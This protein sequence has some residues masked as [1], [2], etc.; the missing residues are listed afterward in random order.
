MTVDDIADI[1][2]EARGNV[3]WGPEEGSLLSDAIYYRQ[4]EASDDTQDPDEREDLE[5]VE[6]YLKVGKRL[7][8][9][10]GQSIPG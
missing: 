9:L 6:E 10:R 7:A 1:I 2:G 5:R 4:G 8:V 3:Y